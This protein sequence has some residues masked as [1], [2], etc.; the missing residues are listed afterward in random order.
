MHEGF[1]SVEK[2][3]AEMDKDGVTHAVLSNQMQDISSLPLEDSV[4]LCRAYNDGISAECVKHKD[5]IQAFAAIPMGSVKAAVAEFDRAMSLPGIVGAIVPGDAF[6]TA[7]RAE[8][9][10]AAARDGGPASRRDP[11][12]LRAAA[13]TIPR[14]RSPISPTTGGCASA[15]STC[16]RASRRAC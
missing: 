9:M 6:L 15:R 5:R 7:K 14:R 4:P 10:G 16:R 2:R 12:P 3:L 8:N 11:R 1:D 13:R